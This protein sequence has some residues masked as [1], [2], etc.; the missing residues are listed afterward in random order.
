MMAPAA[1]SLQLHSSDAPWLLTVAKVDTLHDTDVMENLYGVVSGNV[2]AQQ[3]HKTASESTYCICV[4]RHKWSSGHEDAKA[5]H[6]L[7]KDT[8]QDTEASAQWFDRCQSVFCWS[9]YFDGSKRLHIQAVPDSNGAAE[10]S[11]AHLSL[12]GHSR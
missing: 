9:Q 5:V 3:Q 12:N 2:A 1:C 4:F 11:L 6:G 8:F 10:N 7:L